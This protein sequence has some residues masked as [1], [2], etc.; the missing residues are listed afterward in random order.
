MPIFE[1][2]CCACGA[3]F[4]ALVRASGD[5]RAVVCESCRSR[6]VERRPSVFSAHGSSAPRTAAL[7]RP[8]CGR[9][10]DPDGP[11]AVG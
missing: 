5:E 4:E 6:R 3:E 11:C 1:Y 7:P 8:P 2:R 10:G 9:C